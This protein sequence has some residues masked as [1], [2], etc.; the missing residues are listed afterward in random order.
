M[1]LVRLAVGFSFVAAACSPGEEVV[2]RASP[3]SAEPSP[4][5]AIET[6]SP[7]L[8]ESPPSPLARS[9]ALVWVA[10]EDAGRVVLVDVEREKVLRRVPVPGSPH[11]L[12]VEGGVVVAALQAA[13]S[14]VLVNG[15]RVTD[16]ELGGSPHDVKAMGDRVVVANEGSARVDVLSTDGERL[17]SVD[18]S[19]NPHDLALT[20]DGRTAWV[21]LDATDRIAIVDLEDLAV[22][23]YVPTGRRPHDILVAPDGR[24]WVTDWGGALHV[25]S[26]RGE[27][28]RSI[29]LGVEA[30]HLAF[31]PDG[32]ECWIV[33]HGAHRVFVLD[34][35]TLEV[36]ARLSIH[37]AP[38][39]VA[40]TA[41]GRFAAVADHDNGT[42]VVFDVGRR[43]PVGEVPVGPG[44]HGVWSVT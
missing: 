5:E 23:R 25:L 39:H 44:P 7:K 17:G 10:V 4:A 37:G 6:P 12:T 29:P 36:L 9:A 16:V 11:N 14:I 31:T 43:R 20:P 42:V 8:E 24:V 22:R 35:G 41:D 3:P 19:A 27:I 33:D 13:G 38:H 18:L 15:R 34:V 1:R 2:P 32:R 21:T 30:H 40:I 28:K 26:R